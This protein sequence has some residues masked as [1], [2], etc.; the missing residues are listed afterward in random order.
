VFPGRIL[1]LF[2]CALAIGCRSG[3]SPTIDPDLAARV[4]AP[5]TI[6][7]GVNL[8]TVR[9]SPLRKQLPSAAAA[10]IDSLNGARRV[11]L[12]SDNSNYL[13]LTQG[14]APAG[15][16]SLGHEAAA[17][18]SPEWVQAASHSTAIANG[19][20]V[21]AEPLASGADIWVAVVGGAKLPLTGNGENINGLIQTTEYSVLTIRLADRVELALTGVCRDAES[22]RRLE[23]TVRAMITLGAA[24]TAKQPAISALLHQI[25]L[26][27]DDRTVHLTLTVPIEQME[28]L[29][30]LFG[31][32][33]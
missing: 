6:L 27:R 30:K 33:G 8:E 11:L 7:A 5:A 2:T 20:L 17:M 31:Y 32:S 18:G 23:E 25:R 28:T 24:G 3:P 19:L 1:V 12:A 21:R 9:A 29:L 14:A 15:A 16:T 10:F 4:P 22:G 26:T 13:V